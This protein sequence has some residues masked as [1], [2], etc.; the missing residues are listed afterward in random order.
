MLTVRTITL[1]GENQI[2]PIA[3]HSIAQ[4][5]MDNCTLTVFYVGNNK[6]G[7]EGAVTFAELLRRNLT[8]SI[9]DIGILPHTHQ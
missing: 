7:P 8:I 5:L 1:V 6:L 4:A 2:G 3:M 9:V